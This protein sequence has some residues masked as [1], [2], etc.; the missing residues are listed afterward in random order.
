M[1]GSSRD[2]FI[3]HYTRV[4]KTWAPPR[5]KFF[6]WL[7]AH[8]RCWI[9]DRL[10][11]R[12]LDHP[13][14][15]PLCD[16]KD[17]TLDHLLVSCVLTRDFWFQLLR[18]F[19]LQVLAPQPGLSSFMSS[20]EEASGSVTGPI[21]KGLNS[22][23]ALGAWIIWKHHNKCVFD[24]WTPNNFSYFFFSKAQENCTSLYIKKKR[25]KGP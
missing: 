5:C 3:S 11:K 4:W 15:C 19:D 14:K 2:Q 12:G 24:N 21:R 10:A 7:A 25:L 6:L 20:W 23:I 16:Q 8:N 1:K 18:R 17:E 13:P 22:R 9:A